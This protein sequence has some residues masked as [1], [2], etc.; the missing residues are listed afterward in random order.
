MNIIIYGNLSI[1][2]FPKSINYYNV[3]LILYFLNI[4]ELKLISFK[5]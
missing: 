5:L 2:D 4:K 1:K 3:K